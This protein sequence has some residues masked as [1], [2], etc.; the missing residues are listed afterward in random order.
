MGLRI[1]TLIFF[2]LASCLMQAQTVTVNSFDGISASQLARPMVD[3][4]PNGA[5]GT[6]QYMEWV[7]VYYQGYDKT[8]FA[9]VWSAPQPGITPWQNSGMSNCYGISG[10]GLVLFDRLASRWLISARAQSNGNYYYCI[11]VSNTDDLTSSTL[12]WYTYSFFL[13]PILG[14]DS[15]GRVYFPDWP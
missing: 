15:S 7:N 4:D 1:A 2:F 11:A 3:F 10:D 6:K 5:V 8:T 9:P 14:T 12:A 13:N